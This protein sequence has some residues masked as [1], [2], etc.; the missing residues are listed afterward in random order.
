MLV[1]YAESW[2]KLEL[3]RETHSDKSGYFELIKPDNFIDAPVISVVMSVYNGQKYLRESID[4]ILS[5]TYKNF[6]KRQHRYVLRA[7]KH[8]VLNSFADIGFWYYLLKDL[9]VVCLPRSVKRL[10]NQ[11]GRRNKL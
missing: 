11:F 8:I 3:I 5:Q 1:C 9:S 6:E 10:Y 4:S 7:K 2:N